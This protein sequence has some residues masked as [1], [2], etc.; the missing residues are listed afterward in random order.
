[1]SNTR[2]ATG[3]IPREKASST[4]SA[5]SRARARGELLADAL[6]Q[7]V[8]RVARG[9]RSGRRPSA[10]AGSSARARRRFPRHR[11]VLREDVRR[12]VSLKRRSSSCPA[13]S[14]NSVV[15]DDAS[16]SW[17]LLDALDHVAG[18]NPR[19]GSRIRSPAAGSPY[20]RRR[21]AS[22][23]IREIVDRFP[24]QGPRARA[25][26]SLLPAPSMPVTSRDALP[27]VGDSAGHRVPCQ[28]DGTK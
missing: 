22:R 26:P 6:L 16:L 10:A 12:R 2:S 4:R 15:T 25:A 19:C 24:A 13:Q 14:R 1:M 3:G 11:H 27:V 8:G 7:V 21:A 17:T 18:T 5:S 20:R 9:C 23:R 28:P